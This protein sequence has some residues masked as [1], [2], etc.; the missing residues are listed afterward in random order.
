MSLLIIV[1]LQLL[2][3]QLQSEQVHADI[4]EDS[5]PTIRVVDGGML[6]N[7]VMVNQN[8]NTGQLDRLLGSTGRWLIPTEQQ[9]QDAQRKFGRPLTTD[10]YIYDELGINVF[11]DHKSKAIKSLAV[12]FGG[13]TYSNSPTSPF[14]GNMS[15]KNILVTRKSTFK[16]LEA[17][18]LERTPLPISRDLAIGP[19]KYSFIFDDAAPHSNLAEISISLRS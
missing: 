14:S 13:H 3:G 4:L 7:G 19:F 12:R 18:G 15:V 8:W 9:R 11:V 2:L 6:V 5:P 16:E 1:S 17:L 10:T